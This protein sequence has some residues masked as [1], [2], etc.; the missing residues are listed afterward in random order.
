MAGANDLEVHGHL[1]PRMQL[2]TVAD[3]LNGKR[4]NTPSVVGWESDQQDLGHGPGVLDNP[5][6]HGEGPQ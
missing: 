6:T 1:Y 3:I 5:P 2:L 4:F